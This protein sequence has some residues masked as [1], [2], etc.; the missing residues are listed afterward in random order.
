MNLLT[1]Y[2]SEIE[3]FLAKNRQ[4]PNPKKP[5]IFHSFPP[6]CSDF[7]SD[8]IDIFTNVKEILYSSLQPKNGDE[9]ST[10]D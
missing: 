9:G 5:E 1:Q 2:L 7:N 3:H 8:I 10:T 4:K 6:S